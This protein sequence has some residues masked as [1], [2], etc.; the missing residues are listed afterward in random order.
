MSVDTA[1]GTGENE[2][3]L[4]RLSTSIVVI[5]VITFFCWPY[6][7]AMRHLLDPPPS[8]MPAIQWIGSCAT[9]GGSL[10]EEGCNLFGLYEIKLPTVEEFNVLRDEWGYAEYGSEYKPIPRNRKWSDAA[11]LATKCVKGLIK[12]KGLPPVDVQDWKAYMKTPEWQ[13][14]QKISKECMQ[15][16]FGDN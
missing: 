6:G 13:E 15:K 4:R 2:M 5:A 8:T 12:E 11:Q 3:I 7:Q 9:L 16:A 1:K 10:T 14:R